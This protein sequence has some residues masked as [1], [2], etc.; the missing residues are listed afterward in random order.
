[1]KRQAFTL[2][3]LL[4]VISIIALLV[5]ILL[6]TLQGAREAARTSVCASNTRQMGLAVQVYTADF[7]GFLPPAQEPGAMHGWTDTRH[8]RWVPRLA[9]DGRLPGVVMDNGFDYTPGDIFW[10]PTDASVENDKIINNSHNTS[11][12]PNRSVFAQNGDN[13]PTGVWS[14][15]R[16]DSPSQRL[17]FA[18]KAANDGPNPFRLSFNI[19]QTSGASELV[20]NMVG[21]HAGGTG[22]TGRG[23]MNVTFLDGHVTAM[24]CAEV[25]AP[26]QR[27]SAATR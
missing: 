7:N 1:M 26:A 9:T 27:V 18:E 4:V 3:E 16:Y 17:V 8:K 22:E 20:A 24:T 2:I 23:T 12:T 25:T 21:R 11:Y 10:C 19:F 15:D 5:A 13:N 14:I 6:P